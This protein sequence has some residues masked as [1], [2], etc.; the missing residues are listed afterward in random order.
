MALRAQGGTLKGFARE[1]SISNVTVQKFV[2]AG[3]FPERA[4]KARGPT[5]LDPYRD[6][7]EERIAQ[8][9]RFPELIWQELKQRG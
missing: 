2:H 4:P 7:I 1:L 3:A 9:C 5:P 6:Y 8:G